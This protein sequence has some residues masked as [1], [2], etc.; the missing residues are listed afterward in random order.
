[1]ATEN[2]ELL[3]RKLPELLKSDEKEE[4]LKAFGAVSVNV[5]PPLGH[6]VSSL[7]TYLTIELTSF[8]MFIREVVP[9]PNFLPAMVPERF[10]LKIVPSIPMDTSNR[11]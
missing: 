5:L 2:N 3:I 1:M 8:F 6:M 4:L 11:I 9:L 7:P 10:E